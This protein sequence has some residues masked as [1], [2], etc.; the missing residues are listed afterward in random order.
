MRL[1]R[2]L[3]NKTYEEGRV[4]EL[5]NL[6]KYHPNKVA[7][8]KSF[9]QYFFENRP[10]FSAEYIRLLFQGKNGQEGDGGLVQTCGD[11]AYSHVASRAALYLVCRLLDLEKNRDASLFLDQFTSLDP[12]VLKRMQLHLHIL[13]ERGNRLGAF[14]MV[15]LL[16]NCNRTNHRGENPFSVEQIVSDTWARQEFFAWVERKEMDPASAYR[17]SKQGATLKAPVAETNTYRKI[18]EQTREDLLSIIDQDKGWAVVQLIGGLREERAPWGMAPPQEHLDEDDAVS[19]TYKKDVFKEKTIVKVEAQFSHSVEHVLAVL[20]DLRKQ[21]VW[22]MKFHRGVCACA[23]AALWTHAHIHT[24]TQ[25]H[26]HTFTHIH[27]FD[28]FTHSHNHIRTRSAGK[29]IERLDKGAD[30]AHLVYKSFSSP[31]KYR[32]LCLLRCRLPLPGGHGEGEMLVARSVQHVE[33][34]KDNER[35]NVFAAGFVLRPRDNG[36]ATQL[37]FVMQLDQAAVLIVSPDLLGESDELEMS[38]HN[39]RMML[40]EQHGRPARKDKSKKKEKKK[41]KDKGE[42][43]EKKKKKDKVPE[44]ELSPRAE[45]QPEVVEDSSDDEQ[46]VA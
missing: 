28:T 35:G 40:D 32:D 27:T 10:R 31:Y 18:A 15:H 38:I 29:V 43:K 9:E 4:L 3:A 44:P 45:K 39:I 1:S 14:K 34:A 12:A 41:K 30:V 2:E 7:A 22:D 11:F 8:V 19:V 37:T 24:I 20:V 21:A 23:H 6:L 46:K 5:N 36:R 26:I 33:K 42:K 13:S 16:Q 17:S 25:S